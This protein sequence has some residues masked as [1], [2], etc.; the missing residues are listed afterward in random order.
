MPEKLQLYGLYV[1]YVV[2]ICDFGMLSV[3]NY[4][5]LQKKLITSS[6]GHTLKSTA[7]KL[8]ML[9]AESQKGAIAI[10]FVQQ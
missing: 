4:T 10:D 6:E 3:K 1:Y 8:I 9:S 7:S 2:Q 5:E